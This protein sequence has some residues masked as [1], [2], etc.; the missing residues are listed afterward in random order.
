MTSV[1]K[2]FEKSVAEMRMPA[3]KMFAEEKDVIEK[4]AIIDYHYPNI[5]LER[6]QLPWFI[7]V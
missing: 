4:Y 7:S 6:R 5:K 3:R 2:A 1:K